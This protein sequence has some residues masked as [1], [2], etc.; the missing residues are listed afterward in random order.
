MPNPVPPDVKLEL[1]TM[2]LVPNY[3]NGRTIQY[4][5]HDKTIGPN[6][7]WDVIKMQYVYRQILD[8]VEHRRTR[9]KRRKNP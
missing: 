7:F 6:D 8:G 5:H 1:G 4:W 9:L 2:K 3:V